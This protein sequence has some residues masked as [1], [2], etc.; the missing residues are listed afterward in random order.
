MANEVNFRLMEGASSGALVLSPNVGADQDALLEPGSECLIYRDGLELLDCVSWAALRPVAA[1][2]IG[3]AALQR[4]QAEH[5]PIHRVGQVLR[6]LPGLGKGRLEGRAALQALWLTLA[7]QIRNGVLDLDIGSHAVEG[8][9]LAREDLNV[10]PEEQFLAGQVMAQVFHLFAEDVSSRDKALWLHGEILSMLDRRL[11]DR[12]T[13]ETNALP[14]GRDALAAASAFS[15]KE[16]QLKAAIMLWRE[17]VILSGQHDPGNVPDSVADLCALW[18]GVLEK[19]GRAFDAGFRFDPDRGL[20]P[21]DALGWLTYGRYLEPASRDALAPR[22]DALLADKPPFLALHVGFLA[23]RSLFDPKNWRAQ[24]DFGLC[25]IKACRV[26]EGLHELRE[27]R[28]KA[29]LE[30]RER[31]FFGRLSAWRPAGRVW[32]S[33]L[34]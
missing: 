33:V 14:L 20:L 5:L 32:E 9:K 7:R 11:R 34:G 29:A 26:E 13:G 28:I 23:E 31:L 30:G 27:A 3:R 4:I 19:A 8:L 17:E 25:S 16:G 21:E 15:L 6:D 12:F 18:A 22:F 1:E 2:T 10:T 24:L